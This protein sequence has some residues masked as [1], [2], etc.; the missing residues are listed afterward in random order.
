MI[1]QTS[2]DVAEMMMRAPMI[3]VAVILAGSSASAA[4]PD[5]EQPQAHGRQAAPAPIVLASANVHAP[6]A[7]DAQT[8]TAPAK[9]RPARITACRCGDAQPDPDAQ[10]Q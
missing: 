1:L 6:L 8:T 5:K 10:E 3:T 2:S 9:H 4:Q 7:P